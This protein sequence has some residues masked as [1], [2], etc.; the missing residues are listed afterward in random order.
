[1]HRG[2]PIEVLGNPVQSPMASHRWT[3]RFLLAAR[4]PGPGQT[5]ENDIMSNTYYTRFN[6][7][8]HN[9][10]DH[11]VYNSH[12]FNNN[13]DSFLHD[14]AVSHVDQFGLLN[15]NASPVTNVPIHDNDF[16]LHLF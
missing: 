12:S 13:Q 15:I 14:S 7:I 2:Y 9:R 5:K 16:N 1:M 10:I 11:N 6:T 3:H 8:D 4:A